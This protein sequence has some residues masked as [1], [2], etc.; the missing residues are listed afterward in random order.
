MA[1]L[2]QQVLEK[3]SQN[4]FN[5][6]NNVQVDYSNQRIADYTKQLQ[7]NLDSLNKNYGS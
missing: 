2:R 7:L 1:K 3:R 6:A 4:E 5:V